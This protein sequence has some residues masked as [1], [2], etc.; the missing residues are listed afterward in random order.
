MYE[1]VVEGTAV[2]VAGVD[3]GAVIGA[4]EE[5]LDEDSE[6]TAAVWGVTPSAF[7]AVKT[8]TSAISNDQVKAEAVDVRSAKADLLQGVS[9]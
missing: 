9:K 2:V 7:S 3:A 4:G 1:L 8:G 6:G 5:L